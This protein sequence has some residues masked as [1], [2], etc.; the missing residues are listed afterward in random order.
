MPKDEEDGINRSYWL[1]QSGYPEYVGG[2]SSCSH[3][4]ME[5]VGENDW[6]SQRI[7]EFVGGIAS[8]L[9]KS[10]STENLSGILF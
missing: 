5:Y 3:G 9:R 2:I 10:W 7:L 6:C 1:K 4:I 8:T